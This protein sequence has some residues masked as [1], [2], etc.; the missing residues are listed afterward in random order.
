MKKFFEN[1][2]FITTLANEKLWRR[3]EIVRIMKEM[4]EEN[5]ELTIDH[6]IC[7]LHKLIDPQ[8]SYMNYSMIHYWYSVK[9]WN[10]YNYNADNF[11]LLI[12]RKNIAY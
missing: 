6:F 1:D 3:N 10:D 11:E 2:T 9:I 8:V 12:S 5:P 4:K 7:I